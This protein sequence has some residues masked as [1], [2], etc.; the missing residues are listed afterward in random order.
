MFRLAQRTSVLGSTVKLIAQ[1]ERMMSK[2]VVFNMGGAL[3][4]AMSPVLDK[5]ARSNGMDQTDLSTKL[6]KE[7][8]KGRDCSCCLKNYKASV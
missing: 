8:N 4:P 7:G 6:F 1:Q 5:F 3:V 2:A